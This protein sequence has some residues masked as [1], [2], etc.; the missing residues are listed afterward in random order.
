M[1]SHFRPGGAAP[2]GITGVGVGQNGRGGTRVSP[3][4]PRQLAIE[5]LGKV[6]QDWVGG[7]GAPSRSQRSWQMFD[8]DKG[9]SRLKRYASTALLM[10]GM[11]TVMFAGANYA[12]RFFLPARSFPNDV[13]AA[14]DWP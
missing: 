8:Y 10:I 5:L 1:G 6:E 2:H 14:L 4:A 3:G 7:R 11:L 9:L 13:F 12:A